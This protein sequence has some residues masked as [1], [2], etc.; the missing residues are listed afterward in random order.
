MKSI[1]TRDQKQTEP[2]KQLFKAKSPKTYLKK[3]YINYYYFCQ[4]YKDYF[5]I[6]GII[7]IN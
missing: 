7:G 2:Q 1:Q 4:Q 5:K 3:S 6:L